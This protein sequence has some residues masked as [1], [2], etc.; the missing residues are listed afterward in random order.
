MALQ[1]EFFDKPED[2]LEVIKSVKESND[3]VRKSIF[4]KHGNLERKY[5]ELQERLA[6]IERNICTGIIAMTLRP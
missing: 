3:K 1:L 2:V 5:E 4:A 6:I